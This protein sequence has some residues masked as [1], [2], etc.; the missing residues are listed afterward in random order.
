MKKIGGKHE[1]LRDE[2]LRFGFS[3]C[4]N[5]S[6]AIKT[7]CSRCHLAP[8]CGDPSCWA[9]FW[10]I[11]HK[12]TCRPDSSPWISLESLAEAA[13]RVGGECEDADEETLDSILIPASASDISQFTRIPR[14]VYCELTS[15]GMVTA[16]CEARLRKD[17]GWA[18]SQSTLAAGYDDEGMIP[19]SSKRYIVIHDDSALTGFHGTSTRN[20]FATELLHAPMKGDVLVIATEVGRPTLTTKRRIFDV[21]WV[22]GYL[23][24]THEDP[25]EQLTCRLK[26][27]HQYGLLVDRK[28]WDWGDDD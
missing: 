15:E 14:D 25:F 27:A 18:A 22:R 11:S 2:S 4:S 21:C 28:D 20:L 6:N 5:C 13:D 3:H 24:R 7:Y 17:F 16:E 8:A 26:W 1:G 12:S 9:S 23:A 10:K 19:N